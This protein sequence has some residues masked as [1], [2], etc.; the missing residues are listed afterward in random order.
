MMVDCKTRCLLLAIL[1]VVLVS[2]QA[3][4]QETLWEKQIA[5]A[6]KAYQEGRFADA[7]KSLQAPL[8][9]AERFG[10]QDPRLATILN[11]LGEIYRAQG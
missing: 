9:E 10:P 1:W 6:V 7:E 2:L 3:S 11:I 4:A 5:I 8:K